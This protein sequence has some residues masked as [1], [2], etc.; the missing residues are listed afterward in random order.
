MKTASRMNQGNID[1]VPCVSRSGRSGSRGFRTSHRAT[2]RGRSSQS[3]VLHPGRQRRTF[4]PAFVI[5]ILSE[6]R[7][8]DDNRVLD[9][10]RAWMIERLLVF[11][12]VFGL[13][14]DEL[15]GE[16]QGVMV[17]EKSE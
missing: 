16:L 1:Y 3:I 6:G 14:L 8:D 11:R 12:R 2:S 17:V 13:G 5:A 9:G 7:I 10:I 15:T 4:L